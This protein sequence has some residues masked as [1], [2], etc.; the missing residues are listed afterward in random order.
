MGARLVELARQEGE[1][2]T[3]RSLI[4]EDKVSELLTMPE[5]AYFKSTFTLH[6]DD[7][8]RTDVAKLFERARK[9]GDLFFDFDSHELES[10]RE[11]AESVRDFLRESLGVPEDAL[12]LY[13]SGG[14]G[15]HLLVASAVTGLEPRSDLHDVYGKFA[16]NLR[17]VAKNGTLDVKIY[18][19]RRMFRLVGTVHQK[20][21]RKKALL[22]G[23]ASWPEDLVTSPLLNAALTNVE[24]KE[25][26]NR[27]ASKR[28]PAEFF[29]EPLDCITSIMENGA[30]EG[31]RNDT[32]FTVALYWKALGLGQQ[33]VENK[34]LASALHLKSGLTKQEVITT[35][36]SAFRGDMQFGLRDSVLG[37]LVTDRD[38][39]RWKTSKIDEEY[40]SYAEL[41]TR[42]EDELR[43]PKRIVGK[44]HVKELDERLGGI[45]AGEMVVV[46]GSTGTGKSEFAYHVA[47]EN[48]RQ[49]VPSAFVSLELDNLSLVT[50]RLRSVKGIRPQDLFTMQVTDED[51]K[52]LADELA[53]QKGLNMPLYF[54]KAKSRLTAEELERL[55]QNLILEQQCRLIIIDHLHY[56]AAVGQKFESENQQVS[57][58]I[59]GLNTLALK[60]GVGIMV[61]AHFRKQPDDNH[62]ASIHEFKDSSSI[63][64]EAHTILLLWRNREGIGAEQCVTEI[65]IAKNRKDV[66]L[67]TVE[68][69]FNPETRSYV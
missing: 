52:R 15:Y 10:A 4:E 64:H 43:N 20:T 41:V 6:V 45:I 58:C 18:N 13:E 46:G 8:D 51:R 11:D 28:I 53:R 29:Y 59:K 50:R 56:M 67:S 37:A 3:W 55:I 42:F 26:E 66:P 31:S 22:K 17:H 54:R 35:V 40:E 44:Y 23:P 24:V 7:E 60:Y 12:Q 25:A 65:R 48:A 47:Y 63:E 5:A 32:C 62:R 33:A 16:K 57:H 21:K 30:D 36:N 34:L 1:A 9:S 2:W 61:V 49:S 38:R 14:K 27:R 69:T 19:A 39:Q 68:V